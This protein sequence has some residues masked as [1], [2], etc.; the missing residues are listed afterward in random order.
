MAD[1][2]EYGHPEGCEAFR[3]MPALQAFCRRDADPR[4]FRLASASKPASFCGIAARKFTRTPRQTTCTSSLI[5]SLYG[6]D[7]ASVSSRS[8]AKGM[9]SR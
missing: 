7:V 9:G 2:E 6:V 8:L 4:H 1:S 5:A 3:K